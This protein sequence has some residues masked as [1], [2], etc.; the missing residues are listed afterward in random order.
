MSCSERWPV[1][2]AERYLQGGLD[3][4]TASAWE[5]HYFGCDE[6]FARLKDLR[7]LRGE[8]DRTRRDLEKARPSRPALPFAL[9]AALVGIAAAG[10]FWFSRSRQGPVAAPP[11]AVSIL[12]NLPA[13]EAPPW[14]P[15]LLRGPEDDTVR[16]FHSSMEPYAKGDW[17]GALPLLREAARLDPTAPGPRFY[18]GACALLLGG[19]AEAIEELKK[20]VALGDTPYLE[21]AR[22][23]LARALLESGDLPA[24]REELKRV[25]EQDGGRREAARQLLE[26]LDA[27]TPRPP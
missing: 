11:A 18:G 3:E 7:V 22:F 8:L 14:T 9:A 1:E 27:A 5:E 21:E 12:A 2:V 23:Y 10:A 17:V 16:R 26:R 13:V 19:T 24:A 4:V 6:C 25:V 15:L 20:V